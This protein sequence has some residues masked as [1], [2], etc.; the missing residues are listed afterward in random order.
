MSAEIEWNRITD[1][2]TWENFQLSGHSFRN[3]I[4]KRIKKT[5]GGQVPHTLW[6]VS[7]FIEL[8]EEQRKDIIGFYFRELE[9]TEDFAKRWWTL[10]KHQAFPGQDLATKFEEERA[11]S[12]EPKALKKAMRSCM[13]KAK[14]GSTGYEKMLEA[15]K[16]NPRRTVEIFILLKVFGAGM[17]KTMEERMDQ[18]LREWENRDDCEEALKKLTEMKLFP[19]SRWK[20]WVKEMKGK[21]ERK[22]EE[23]KDPMVEEVIAVMRESRTKQQKWRT[24]VR[25]WM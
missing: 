24:K 14:G 6:K 5:P 11:K 3:W 13:M 21:A 4:R 22:E 9:G 18:T 12:E 16:G 15:T 8:E 19:K 1:F 2:C 25:E 10:A 20:E 7:R 23:V 17:E